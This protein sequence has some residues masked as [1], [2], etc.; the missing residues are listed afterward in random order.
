MPA[1]N[2]TSHCHEFSDNGEYE[3]ACGCGLHIDATPPRELVEEARQMAFEAGGLE[4][5]EYHLADEELE[6]IIQHVISQTIVDREVK[7]HDAQMKWVPVGEQ[8]PEPGVPVLVFVPNAHGAD[9]NS[10]RLRAQYAAEKTLE[11]ADCCDGGTYDEETDTYWCELG[12]YENN[13]F[14][15]TH[16]AIDGTVTHWMP[17]PAAPEVQA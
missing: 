8:L 13:E 12:W 16:W 14:E 2:Q 3:V 10:R 9:G 15:D 11:Q 6:Q 17:L 5:G 7:L 4:G 1:E